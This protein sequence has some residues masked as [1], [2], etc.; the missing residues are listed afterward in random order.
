[1]ANELRQLMNTA[2]ATI[3][4]IKTDEITDNSREEAFY[5]PLNETPIE[6]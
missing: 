4:A 2:N 1:M 5:A 3:V 6:S